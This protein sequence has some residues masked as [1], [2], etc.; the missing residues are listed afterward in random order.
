MRADLHGAFLGFP[1]GLSIICLLRC[2]LRSSKANSFREPSNNCVST[3]QTCIYSAML[4]LRERRAAE[5][6][7]ALPGEQTPLAATIPAAKG[8][9]EATSTRSSDHVLMSSARKA[10][11]NSFQCREFT[12]VSPST[13]SKLKK[14]IQRNRLLSQQRG[15]QLVWSLLFRDQPPILTVDRGSL[16]FSKR[17]MMRMC[18]TTLD[19][20][21][22]GVKRTQLEA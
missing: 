2:T 15:A 12:L 21:Q 14:P 5:K 8:P 18:W 19:S 20:S 6:G 7:H 22:L 11:K 17:A 9:S 3:G 1:G 16:E 4:P 13:N 10:R